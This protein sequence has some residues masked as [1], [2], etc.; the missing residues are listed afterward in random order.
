MRSPIP[1]KNDSPSVQERGPLVKKSLMQNANG[2]ANTPTAGV[3][4]NANE[5]LA[6]VA[7]LVIM[8]H[9]RF[10]LFRQLRVRHLA[11]GIGK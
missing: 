7:R 10:S 4:R 5:A 2:S 11:F 9:R 3:T 8:R 6:I 1:A